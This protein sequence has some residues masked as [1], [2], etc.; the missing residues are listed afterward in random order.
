[1]ECWPISLNTDKFKV[2]IWRFLFSVGTTIFILSHSLTLLLQHALTYVGHQRLKTCCYNDVNKDY[3]CA[4]RRNH[5]LSPETR[6]SAQWDINIKTTMTMLHASTT[7]LLQLHRKIKYI[8]FSQLIL[9]HTLDLSRNIFC[10]NFKNEVHNNNIAYLFYKINTRY[11]WKVNECT[12][13][14]I[15]I[16]EDIKAN[17][18]STL[19]VHLMC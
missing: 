12:V 19:W 5:S 7:T 18:A 17:T 1:M 9:W 13:S 8:K 3:C 14:L 11:T 2:K 6:H 15:R 10:L 4:N 16:L